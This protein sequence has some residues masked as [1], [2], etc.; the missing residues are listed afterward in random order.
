MKISCN[1]FLA[2]LSAYVMARFNSTLGHATQTDAFER[3]EVITGETG[4]T[5]KTAMR[6]SFDYYFPWR[7][8]WDL[9]DPKNRINW[10]K[11]ELIEIF[12]VGN[13]RSFEELKMVLELFG[14]WK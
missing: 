4:E 6:D 1:E 3:I 14:V 11:Y 2:A 10:N 12:N 8:G 9:S 13:N 7:K 5:V